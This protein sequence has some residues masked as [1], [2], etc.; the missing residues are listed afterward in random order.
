M[1]RPRHFSDFAKTGR[2]GFFPATEE[3][4][5]THFPHTSELIHV[6]LPLP[7]PPVDRMKRFMHIAAVACIF[8]AAPEV[9]PCAWDSDTLRDEAVQRG[10]LYDIITG[11]FPHHGQGYYRERVKRLSAKEELSFEDKNDLAIA[12]LRLEKW[13]DAEALL[14]QNLAAQ[15]NDYF[16]LSNLGV[17]EKKRGNFSASAAWIEKA[18]AL[19]HPNEP[20]VRRRLSKMYDHFHMATFDGGGA[21][22]Y[23]AW[24]RKIK[25]AHDTSATRAFADAKTWLAEYQKAEATLAGTNGDLST[26]PDK[27]EAALRSQGISRPLP[28]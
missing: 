5:D 3:I 16:T 14:N 13:A 4:Q 28:K 19:R 11:Q 23:T 8:A 9:R 6:E 24:M 15:P 21:K 25:A 12:F 10:S 22:A 26:N 7:A 1:R 20:E 18:L 27:V 2:P 17:L